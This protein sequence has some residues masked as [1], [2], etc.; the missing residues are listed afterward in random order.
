M[1]SK[2]TTANIPDQSGKVA[3]GT[4]ANSGIGYET[5]KALAAKGATVIMAC[6]N[7]E[8]AHA[9]ADK[10]KRDVPGAKLDI[11]QLDL[12]DLAAVREFAAQFQARY[13]QLNLLINNAGIMFPPFTETK[14]G[15]EVQFGANHLGH[16]ALTGL[17]LDTLLVTSGARV[18]NVSSMAHRMGKIDFDNLNA[19][20]GYNPSAAYA[21][22]KLA[23]LLFSLE[24]NRQF[25]AHGLD[26]MAVSAHP[27]WT[28]T[29]LQ[30][31]LMATATRIVG[32][33]A[34]MGALP[35][36]R[37][38]TDPNVRPNEYYGPAR[39]VEV[40]GYPKKVGTIAAA[41]DVA[42]AQKLWHVSE[43]M[44]GVRYEW[45]QAIEVA[46]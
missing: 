1:S 39:F 30:R 38:A 25:E 9:A 2:W 31:G 22:S 18:V 46:G 32:Q 23:N 40:R 5:A 14:D 13:D 35:T 36:L 34:P 33:S 20:K 15:F 27:G 10:I 8:K 28:A 26:L 29:N 42:L 4:G 19:E 16:F 17:L 44:T 37:A 24:L 3:I 45:N 6:R 11:I 7:L 43:E 41:Q 21:Q 12:A